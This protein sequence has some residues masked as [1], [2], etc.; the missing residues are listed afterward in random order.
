MLVAVTVAAAA[1]FSVICI[2]VE[3]VVVAVVLSSTVAV[4]SS[5]EG[6]TSGLEPVW[7]PV[8]ARSVSLFTIK[9]LSFRF[10]FVGCTDLYKDSSHTG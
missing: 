6:V 4:H 5:F 2:V 1:I 10:C 9:S 8:S 7:R 3:T